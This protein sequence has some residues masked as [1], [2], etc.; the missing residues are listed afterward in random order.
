LIRGTL[1]LTLSL[2]RIILIK[3]EK[4]NVV[5]GDAQFLIRSGL[6]KLISAHA[7][8]EL[9]AQADK[10]ED[11]LIAVKSHTPNVVI[12]DYLSKGFGLEL[13]RDIKQTS[14][15]SKI[16]IISTDL[17][18]GNIFKSI[19]LGA[20]SFVTKNCSEEEIV[21]AIIATAKNER[22]FCNRILEVF[23]DRSEEKPGS[24]RPKNLTGRE[25]EILRLIGKGHSTKEIAAQLHLSQHTIYTHRKNMMKKLGVNASTEMVLAAVNLGLIRPTIKTA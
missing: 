18:R 11:V 2:F 9:K 4:I 3:V 15:G 10:R 23:I 17:V 20:N 1:G 22:F 24:A 8:F 13:I 21:N 6:G 12:L 5:L 19:E 7:S 16:L 14:P 25:V